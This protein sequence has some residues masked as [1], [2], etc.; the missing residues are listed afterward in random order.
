MNSNDPFRDNSWK[1]EKKMRSD[2]KHCL[3]NW[4]GF[5]KKPKAISTVVNDVKEWLMDLGLG[6][7]TDLFEMHEVDEK[8]L[9]LPSYEDLVEMGITALGSRGG[10]IQQLGFLLK[11][12]I[13][14]DRIL[15]S[16]KFSLYSFLCNIE[17]TD[18]AI[19]KPQS[20][21]THIV[22]FSKDL[23][24]NVHFMGI[25]IMFLKL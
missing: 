10:Y 11:E 21:L 3:I 2:R 1:R 23:N 4:A 14:Q 16:R 20:H 7:Y 13:L 25:R 6:K 22:S 19:Y 8:A 9:P 12:V 24:V 17:E 15:I 5:L 18:N